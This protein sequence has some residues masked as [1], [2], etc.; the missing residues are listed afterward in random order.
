MQASGVSAQDV[1]GR[2]VTITL[3]DKPLDEALQE[4]SA[5]SKVKFAYPDKLVKQQKPITRRYDNA[6]LEQV[7]DDMLK[8]SGLMHQ[9]V[10]DIVVIKKALDRH[11]AALRAGQDHRKGH[12]CRFFGRAVV[13]GFRDC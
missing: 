3:K 4:I 11:G 1:L 9:V 2:G 6:R 5:A 12:G 7:L 10:G 13:R 8:E